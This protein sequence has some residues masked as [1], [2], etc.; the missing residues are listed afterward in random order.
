[1]IKK[2][3]EVGQEKRNKSFFHQ[4]AWIL[5]DNKYNQIINYFFQHTKTTTYPLKITCY[6][7]SGRQD[8]NLRPLRPERSA[9]AKLSYSPVKKRPKLYYNNSYMAVNPHFH[10]VAIIFCFEIPANFFF[11]WDPFVLLRYRSRC[12]AEDLFGWFSLYN[13]FQGP[14]CRVYLP[15]LPVLCSFS[16]LI[17]KTDRFSLSSLQKQ[18]SRNVTDVVD[19]R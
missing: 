4:P 2:E 17:T 3:D 19:S 10:K 9:L 11:S 15:P 7:L 5:R 8:L 18:G 6:D 1:M 12:A 16:L 14:F 13:N